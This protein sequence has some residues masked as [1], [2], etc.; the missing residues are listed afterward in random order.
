MSEDVSFHAVTVTA[1]EGCTVT[2]F[3][4]YGFPVEDGVTYY[5][6]VDIAEGYRKTD[7]F[8]VK[9]NGN[10]P[11]LFTS[12][13][14]KGAYQVNKPAGEQIIEVT[15]AE[16]A[17]YNVTLSD[18]VEGCQI[19]PYEGFSLPVPYGTDYSFVVEIE[20]GYRKASGYGVYANGVWLSPTHGGASRTIQNV[21]T[22][23]IVTVE[24]V[25]KIPEYY[26]TFSEGE[27]YRVNPRFTSPV[28]GSSKE[29]FTVEILDGY[30]KTDGF[31]VRAN[32]EPLT[33]DSDNLYGLLGIT[34][35]IHITVEGVEPVPPSYPVT[36]SPGAKGYT[37]TPVGGSGFAVE[38]GESFSFTVRIEYGYRKGSD[39]SVSVN[40]VK[41]TAVN[42]VYTI[43]NVIAPQ[44]VSADGVIYVFTPGPGHKPDYDFD[45]DT[46]TFVFSVVSL[47]D[48]IVSTA[49]GFPVLLFFGSVAAFLI[50]F[51]IFQRLYSNG[52]R[53]R[54][55]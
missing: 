14:Y 39:F 53:R 46:T 18:T 9:V 42:G 8:S 29:W 6:T 48:S 43:R 26:I 22:D 54:L 21:T 32:G 23:Q 15:G 38:E 3:R 19:H 5:F 4:G 20:D 31:T 45:A 13:A 50:C 28:D 17:A 2:P 36:I 27:G 16:R 33:A 49:L 24:G 1:D 7:N 12:G 35:D 10:K 11:T 25:E 51:A 37:I 55:H 47:F 44:T 41:L 40:G 34:E 52:K 30:R